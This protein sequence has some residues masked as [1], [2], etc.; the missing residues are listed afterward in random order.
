MSEFIYFATKL[1]N[2][3]ED[4]VKQRYFDEND[5]VKE[6]AADEV[7]GAISKK[8]ADAKTESQQNFDKGFQKA[9]AKYKSAAEK[10]F[11]EKTGIELTEGR[12]LDEMIE[13][14]AERNRK[15][16][17]TDADIKTHP[18]YRD[19]EKSTVKVDEYNKLKSEHEQFIANFQRKSLL[20]QVKPKVWG[21]VSSMNPILEQN[22][23]VADTR[24]NMF[25]SAFDAYDYQIDGDEVIVMKDGNR[26][27]DQ[28]KNPLKFD[29]FVK[30]HAAD[31]FEFNKQ[32]PKGGAGNG[33]GGGNNGSGF[34]IPMPKSID[35]FNAQRAKLSGEKLVKYGELGRAHLQ[36]LGLL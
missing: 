6:N 19:L 27:E 31:Y 3:T 34:D 5:A 30:S 13:E 29:E 15:K 11:A 24:K 36:R 10:A 8:I 33:N 26:I 14:Y 20:D 4:E 12:T 2:L 9:E 21:I 16:S 22:P 28:F 7:L 32:D 1:L 23:K 18:L 25:L 17:L 35:E